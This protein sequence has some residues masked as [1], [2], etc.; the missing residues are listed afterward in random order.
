MCKFIKEEKIEPKCHKKD[1]ISKKN[2]NLYWNK[3]FFSKICIIK[4]VQIGEYNENN[5][6]GT[7]NSVKI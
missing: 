5:L 1:K 2:Q 3:T 4:S 7:Y 6:K